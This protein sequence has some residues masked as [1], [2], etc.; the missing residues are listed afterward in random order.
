MPFPSVKKKITF[1]NVE[2][3]EYWCEFKTMSG[4]KYK[5]V[6]AMLSGNDPEDNS[7]DHVSNLLEAT[8]LAWNLPEE[9]GGEVLPIPATDPT[10]IEK[11]PNIIITHLVNEISG[12]DGSAES[13]NL[14]Q[15]S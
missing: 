3:P 1:D 4:M 12:S 15:T 14:E 11:L 5:E 2:C 7:I 10:S 8:I 6:R 9:D 13:E